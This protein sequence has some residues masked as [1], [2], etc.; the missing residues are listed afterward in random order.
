MHSYLIAEGKDVD[1]FERQ[2][3]EKH[4]GRTTKRCPYKMNK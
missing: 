3:G 1:L 4:G 2:R